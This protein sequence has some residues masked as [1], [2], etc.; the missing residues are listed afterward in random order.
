MVTGAGEGAEALARPRLCCLCARVCCARRR[1][2]AARVASRAEKLSAA[3]D[4]AAFICIGEPCS[5]P[6][7]EP[8]SLANP[9]HA[10][11]PTSSRSETLVLLFNVTRSPTLAPPTEDFIMPSVFGALLA[12]ATL[13]RCAPPRHT[14]VQIERARRRRGP[15]PHD[16]RDQEQGQSYSRIV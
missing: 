2:R 11:S 1:R 13:K 3:T 7:T 12:V 8:D 10:M 9:V 5:L 15:L 16:L 6:V 4:R 14:A